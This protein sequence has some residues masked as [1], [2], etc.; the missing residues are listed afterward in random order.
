MHKSSK[1]IVKNI[2]FIRHRPLL[3]VKR[4]LRSAYQTIRRCS[5]HHFNPGEFL[6]FR[7]RIY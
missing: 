4:N 2:E 5:I 1:E 7:M 6:I 3:I